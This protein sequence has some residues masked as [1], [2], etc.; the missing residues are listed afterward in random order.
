M[1]INITHAIYKPGARPEASAKSLCIPPF[2]I[3]YLLLR[4]V[5]SNPNPLAPSPL[6]LSS[7]P[8]PSAL[9][10]QPCGRAFWPCAHDVSLARVPRLCRMVVSSLE[11]GIHTCLRACFTGRDTCL[12]AL[13]HLY[14]LDE[15]STIDCA[16]MPQWRV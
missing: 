14:S 13:E 10:S 12:R 4:I 3:L 6:H 15:T 1:H 16:C 7:K 8:A 5:K 9:H 11:H 2:A